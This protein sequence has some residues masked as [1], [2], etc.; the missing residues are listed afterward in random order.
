MADLQAQH[1]RSADFRSAASQVCNLHG[2]AQFEAIARRGCSA[3]YNVLQQIKNLRSGLG[4]ALLLFSSICRA[5]VGDP[6][7]KTDHPWYPGELAYSTFEEL[8]ATQAKQYQ[9]AVGTTPATEE[10]KALASW[11]WRNTHYWHGE[12]GAA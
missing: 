11:F 2:S 8:F 12:E 6:Q 7:I 3:D 5:D 1:L 10:E 9:Q 4:A